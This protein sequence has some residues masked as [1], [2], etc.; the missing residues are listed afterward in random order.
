[1]T[2]AQALDQCSTKVR[3][4]QNPLLARLSGES[5]TARHQK[6][7]SSKATFFLKRE[8]FSIGR[9]VERSSAAET[10]ASGRSSAQGCQKKRSSAV[11]RSLHCNK[12]N[13]IGRLGV[14]LTRDQQL[15]RDAIVA[16][17]TGA[18]GGAA[19]VATLAGY[20]GVGKTTVVAQAVQ[21]LSGL[22]VAVTA[23]THKAVA[24]LRDKLGGNPAVEFA[25]IHSLL[26]LRLKETDDGAHKIEAEGDPSLHSFQF[27]V[28]DECSMI[29]DTLF[30]SVL[31]RRGLCRVLFVGDPAQL[32][33]VDSA[34]GSVSPSFGAH[35]PLHWRL[36]EV[37]RQ[38]RENPII[39]VA[40]A[41]RQCIT[42]QREFGLRDVTDSIAPGDEALMGVYAG[43]DVQ[44]AEMTADAI[45]SGLEVRALAFDN[46][47]VLRV[48][49][50]VHGILHPGAAPWVVG[51]PV[52][53]QQPFAMSTGR[54]SK[55]I[56]VQ[57]SELLTVHAVHEEG[58]P[59]EP[60]RPAWRISL[61]QG[62]GSIG[63]VYVARDDRALQTDISEA[64]NEHRRAK[65][66]S[67]QAASASES[68]RLRDVARDASKRGWALRNRY[69]PIRLAYAMTVHKSQG[70]TFDATVVAWQSFQRCRDISQ[71]SRLA[72]VALTRT[73]KFTA[74]VA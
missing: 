65:L 52:I 62:D 23:P 10:S 4:A 67:I 9:A 18:Y 47:T 27:A 70:S 53:A 58:H 6:H 66:A 64:F 19:S 32:P 22:R 44:I 20:A 71:R 1:M 17:A 54:T 59:D 25:T 50:M 45:Q 74:I 38:A 24:V 36:T 69:A 72:Y 30:A 34:P 35:V 21:A 56:H 5:S 2:N 28:V 42:E 39:R 51:S 61:K 68:G 33:P 31:S 14:D 55:R 49:Q 15:V 11:E 43:S 8:K 3:R 26:G 40:T 48:N 29:S 7:F 63:D 41:A 12:I 57:N 13:R 16:F 60:H 73:S 46:A 37:V